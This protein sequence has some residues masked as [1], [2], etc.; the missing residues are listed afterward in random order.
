MRKTPNAVTR[1]GR[2]T[3][4]SWLTQ[5]SLA[6]TMN[7]GITPSWVGNSMVPITTSSSALRP[8]KRSLAKAK[9][10]SVQHTTVPAAMELDTINELTRA[11]PMSACCSAWWMLWPR[12]PPGIS[13]G[14]TWLMSALEWVAATIVQ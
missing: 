11:L 6:M 5:G 4:W 1:V 13:G 12:F 8:R 10:A 14:G 2:I 3:D 7:S 9:P